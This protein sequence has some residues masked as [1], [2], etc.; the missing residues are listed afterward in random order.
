ERGAT[1]LAKRRFGRIFSA[2]L[3][4]ATRQRTATR[5]AELPAGCA[6][7]PAL[8]ATH[9]PYPKPQRPLVNIR[10]SPLAADWNGQ[11]GCAY[12]PFAIF[13]RGRPPLRPLARELAALVG[14]CAR[15]PTA[16]SCAAIQRREPKI[17]RS[18]AG[19]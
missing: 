2:A 1:V 15:P 10:R 7:G 9:A 13:V 19:I 14:L 4:T 3:R 6:F 11:D 18:N 16:P 5:G 12:Q 8:G 17:P